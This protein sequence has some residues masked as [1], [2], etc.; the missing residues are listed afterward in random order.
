MDSFMSKGVNLSVH[1][2]LPD[3]VPVN[4]GTDA[5]GKA[6]RNIP[7]R[8]A[9]GPPCPTLPGR[10]GVRYAIVAR[11]SELMKVPAATHEHSN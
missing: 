3:Q 2:L 8:P 6:H 10:L 4:K 1:V 11:P 7:T 5:Y 9:V